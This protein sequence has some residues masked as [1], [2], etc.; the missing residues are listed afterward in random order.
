MENICSICGGN[1]EDVIGSEDRQ[2]DTCWCI[3]HSDGS[4]TD[5]EEE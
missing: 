5:W 4:I 1:I 3:V 2:C